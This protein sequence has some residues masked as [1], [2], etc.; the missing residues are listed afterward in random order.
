[1]PQSA[2]L[3]AGG[4]VQWLFGQCP[5]EHRFFYVGASLND[6]IK[7]ISEYKAKDL[8]LENILFDGMKRFRTSCNVMSNNYNKRLC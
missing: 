3:S 1:M 6:H 8:Y 2:R 5:N 7:K 4:G